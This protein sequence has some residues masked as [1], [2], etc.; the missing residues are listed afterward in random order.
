MHIDIS[1]QSSWS[2]EIKLVEIL[3]LFPPRSH[4]PI[5]GCAGTSCH[6]SISLPSHSG[7]SKNLGETRNSTPAPPDTPGTVQPQCYVPNPTTQTKPKDPVQLHQKASQ[8]AGEQRGSGWGQLTSPRNTAEKASAGENGAFIP[9]TT[10]QR[11]QRLPAH[12]D[13]S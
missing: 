11:R 4:Q 13:A 1:A 10:S 9:Q 2:K 3:Q 5:L 7:D 8:S 6:Q 12:L